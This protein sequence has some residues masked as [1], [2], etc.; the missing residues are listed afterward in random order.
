MK[1]K[2]LLLFFLLSC[3]GLEA[4]INVENIQIAR[5][6]WGVPHIFT[7]TDEEAAYALAWA[8]AEDNFEQIQEPLLSARNLLGS[9]KGKE[10]ALFD[11]LSFLMDTEDLVEREYEQAFSPKFK[12]ILEAYCSGLNRYAALHP[13]Q[14]L[15]EDVFPVS[16][17]DI[18]KG[19]ALSFSLISNIQFDIGRLFQNQLEP[20]TKAAAN[21]SAG[22]NGIAIAPHKTIDNKTYLVSNSHQPFRSYMSWYEVHIHTEEGWNFTGATFAGGITPFIGTNQ[23]LG[24]THCVNYHD[25]NDVYAL[26]MHPK[27][28]LKYYMDGRWLDLEERVWKTK[29]KVGFLKLGIKKKFYWSVHGPVIKNK[30]G[31]FALRFAAN[32]VVGAPEQ[33]YHMNKARNYKEFRVAV[34]RQQFPN[35]SIVYAD[36]EGN[37]EMLDNGLFPYRN[38]QYDW[39]KIVPGDTSATLWQGQFMP[40]DSLLQVVNPKSGYVFHVNGTGFN[41][42]GE[43]ENPKPEQFNTTMGY[44]KRNS[45]R[46]IR[47]Q[48]LIKQYDKLSMEDVKTIK[49]DQHRDFPLYTRSIENWDLLR[50]I[51]PDK[52]PELADIIAVFSKWDGSGDVHNKQAAIF[53]LSG[54]YISEYTQKNGIADIEGSLPEAVF[55]KAL[56]YAKKYLKKHFGRLEIELGELQKHVRGDKILPVGGLAESLAALYIVPHKKGIKQSNLGDSFILFA[57]YG[58][59]GVETIES[60]NCYGSSN[61]PESPHYNDQME[62]YIEQKTKKITLDKTLILNNAEK[63]YSPQ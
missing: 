16:P 45:A 11:A 50:H 7:K 9:V 24:W 51:S 55:P 39:T 48:K 10:G 56:A 18:I 54:N 19:Y 49:Y 17:K 27:K 43:T 46:N 32:M 1:T 41:S 53:A 62:L 22:S 52:H 13:Q 25:F 3:M 6:K 40:V 38:P 35:L 23:D 42:T 63:I 12:K 59:D 44:I 26:K 20:I 21:T 47:F 58:P 8:H 33:W 29:V 36:K 31:Y 15:L 34:N 61:R 14:L 5:D 30:R 60:V 28:K 57:T 37:I 2:Y 4:Q